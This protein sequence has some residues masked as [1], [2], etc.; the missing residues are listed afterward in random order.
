MLNQKYAILMYTFSN[1]TVIF[2]HIN[3]IHINILLYNIIVNITIEYIRNISIISNSINLTLITDG[4]NSLFHETDK[5]SLPLII[6][7]K[8]NLP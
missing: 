1:S 7:S 4:I 2:T 3:I 8:A 6:V 5:S